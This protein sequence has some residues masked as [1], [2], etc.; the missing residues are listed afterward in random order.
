MRSIMLYL[1]VL[2][3]GKHFP[4]SVVRKAQQLRCFTMCIVAWPCL[5]VKLNSWV[6]G[7]YSCS[8]V[9]SL[10]PDCPRNVLLSLIR[11]V[12]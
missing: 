1:K 12:T 10:N 8:T 7:S 11:L 6:H 2:L 9:A 5:G 3:F 4:F